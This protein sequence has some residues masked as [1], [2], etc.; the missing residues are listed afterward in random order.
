M[1][2]IL[3]EAVPATMKNIDGELQKTL[4]TANKYIGESFSAAALHSHW[5]ACVCVCVLSFLWAHGSHPAKPL[6]N[7]ALPVSHPPSPQ[8]LNATELETSFATLSIFLQSG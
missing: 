2:A 4:V 1:P 3:N 5:C 7:L 6:K 8:K